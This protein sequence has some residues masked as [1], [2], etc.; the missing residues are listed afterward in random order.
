MTFDGF[1]D[2]WSQD[3]WMCDCGAALSPVT[4]GPGERLCWKCRNPGEVV[5][6]AEI[7]CCDRCQQAAR[8]RIQ[9]PEGMLCPVCGDGSLER[10]SERALEK[11][12]R[13]GLTVRKP[14]HVLV[15]LA[16]MQEE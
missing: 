2:P 9:T 10:Q 3:H 12:E 16:R 6:P 1:D 11:A 14:K 4:S 5:P 7:P 8:V 13:E 15:A